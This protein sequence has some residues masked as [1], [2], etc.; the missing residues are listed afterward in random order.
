M[1]ARSVCVALV[2]VVA[3]SGA[4]SAASEVS[5]VPR[6]LDADTIATGAYK[7]RLSG[8]DAP[9][10]DQVCLDAKGQPW[11]CGI[12]ARE[13]LIKFSHDRIWSCNLVGKDRY[14]RQ[15]GTCR[16]G[17]EDVSRWLVRNG[18][19]LAFRR[20]STEY[21]SDEEVAR[22]ERRGLWA[23][24]FIAP[25]DWRK[26]GTSTMVLGAVD[27]PVGAQRDLISPKT[28]GSPLTSGCSIKANLKRD[29][30]IYHV[31]GGQF[32]GRLKMESTSQR[33]WFC[34]E[35]EAE[36]AGCRKSKR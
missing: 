25:W 19:A 9:E 23:G 6:I 3:V 14:G 17:N 30:C 11:N 18:W 28:A 10:S 8:V 1:I 35:A 32:Y 12:E 24:A 29:E 21:V 33:R 22:N 4:A 5:G 20:Y 36:A 7:I 27:V 26:R 2:C 34:S 15:I 16:V 31:P 13:Q